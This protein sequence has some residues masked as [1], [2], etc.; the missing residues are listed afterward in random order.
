[1]A[2]FVVVKAN[3]LASVSAQTSTGIAAMTLGAGDIVAQANDGTIS[4]HDANGASP[5]NIVRGIALHDSL[6]G[7]PITYARTDPNFSPGYAGMTAG[8]SVIAS[9]TPGGSCPDADKLTGW[10][11]TELGRAIDASH[12]KLN[13]VKTGVVR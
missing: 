6:A 2:D 7:Q 12:Y 10:Y 3:V 4:Q 8:D 9:A 11:V 5:L 1:M 13:I